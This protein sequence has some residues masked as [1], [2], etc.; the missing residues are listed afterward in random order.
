MTQSLWLNFDTL[1]GKWGVIANPLKAQA[2]CM[3]YNLSRWLS[4]QPLCRWRLA[5]QTC[6]VLTCWLYTHRGHKARRGIY[7]ECKTT[8]M[9]GAWLGGT[10]FI[11]GIRQR[12]GIG[13]RVCSRWWILQPEYS[14]LRHDVH[15][16][17]VLIPLEIF[18]IALF[19]LDS[20]NSYIKFLGNKVGHSNSNNNNNSNTVAWQKG[21]NFEKQKIGLKLLKQVEMDNF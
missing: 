11:V 13:P 20:F 9:C 5:C 7:P 19:V 8:A 15:S 12:S 14:I 16:R 1:T 17:A 2:S 3:S 6:I 10:T 18:V 21:W 4:N